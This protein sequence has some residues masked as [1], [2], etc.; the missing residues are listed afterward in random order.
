MED[1]LKFFLEGSNELIHEYGKN[2]WCLYGKYL[3]IDE[4]KK[5]YN[6]RGTE[7]NLSFPK[8]YIFVK[9]DKKN[10]DIYSQS[11]KKP[12]GNINSEYNGLEYI[13][14]SGVIMFK[15]RLEKRLDELKNHK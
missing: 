1:H 13:T 14:A 8:G 9:I 5:F 6:I 11:G 4:C 15:D 3:Y 12:R 7:T 2:N 10:G